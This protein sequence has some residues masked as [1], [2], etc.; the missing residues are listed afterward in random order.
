M[1][2]RRSLGAVVFLLSGQQLWKRSSAWQGKQ[3]NLFLQYC[4]LCLSYF[5]FLPI[6]RAYKHFRRKVE[7]CRN[8]FV[9]SSARLSLPETHKRALISLNNSFPVNRSLLFFCTW[10]RAEGRRRKIAAFPWV[11]KELHSQRAQ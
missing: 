7:V 3:A 6:F 9:S 2:K 11:N 10:M 1:C 4:S 8:H 5:F